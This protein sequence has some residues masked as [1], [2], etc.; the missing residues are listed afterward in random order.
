MIAV[1]TSKWMLDIIISIFLEEKM[2][3]RIVSNKEFFQ[4]HILS[5]RLGY[6]S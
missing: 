4:D 6:K 1:D 2:D 5:K 3:F